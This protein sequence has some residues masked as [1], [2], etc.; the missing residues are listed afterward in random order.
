MFHA[1]VG[2]HFVSDVALNL[3]DHATVQPLAIGNLRTQ[4]KVRILHGSWLIPNNVLNAESQL[5]KIKDAIT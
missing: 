5:R 2:T 1:N 3:T 4:Q